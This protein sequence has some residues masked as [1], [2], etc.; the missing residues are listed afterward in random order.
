M[1]H[2]DHQHRAGSMYACPA[3]R[4]EHPSK[5]PRAERPDLTLIPSPTAQAGDVDAEDDEAEDIEA[6]DVDAGDVDAGGV[7]GGATVGVP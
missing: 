1:T 4:E 3:C 2:D 7:G 5:Q 6:G